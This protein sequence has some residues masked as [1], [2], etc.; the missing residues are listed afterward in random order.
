MRPRALWTSLARMAFADPIQDVGA[1][2]VQNPCPRLLDAVYRLRAEAWR[3]RVPS[4]PALERWRD[5]HDET[6]SHFVIVQRGAPIAAA[7]LTLHRSLADAPDATVYADVEPSLLRGTVAVLSRLVVSASHA[8]A[9]LSVALDRARVA[10]AANSGAQV[11]FV[12]TSVAQ[13]IK[14][15]VSLGFRALY[16]ARGQAA[17]ALQS[18]APPVVL[19]RDILVASQHPCTGGPP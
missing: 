17:G 19:M 14:S 6:A 5:G 15:L 3:A 2:L 12:G 11:A 1:E 8:G 18:V 10:E 16:T 4:F 9:G 13:R 7:R